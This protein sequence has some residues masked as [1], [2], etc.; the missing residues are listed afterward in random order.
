MVRSW[1]VERR[2]GR[3]ERPRRRLAAR[4]RTSGGCH[5][6]NVA[7]LARA[8]ATR[9]RSEP[10]RAQSACEIASPLATSFRALLIARHAGL[11]SDSSSTF[12]HRIN[13]AAA[14]AREM[15]SRVS[16]SC[17]IARDST[18]YAKHV[19][20]TARSSA[21]NC[22]T[23]T[24]DRRPL[25]VQVELRAKYHHRAKAALINRRLQR[26]VRWQAGETIKT[27]SERVCVQVVPKL[28]RLHANDGNCAQVAD[29]WFEKVGQF[30]R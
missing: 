15:P 13:N 21:V 2:K 4:Q 7:Y 12:G 26:Y 3:R 5:P 29:P 19:R 24:V 14:S 6:L 1:T 27:R 18:M 10:S 20:A 22:S 23:Y 28:L 17:S 16:N 30:L 11:S 25:K 8:A 9:G